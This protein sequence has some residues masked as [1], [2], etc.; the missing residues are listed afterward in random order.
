ML[1]LNAAIAQCPR[2]LFGDKEKKE[3]PK[4]RKIF[5]LVAKTLLK[6]AGEK[7][8]E[9][10]VD[11]VAQYVNPSS[12]Q[13]SVADHRATIT[14]KIDT[15][16][17]KYLP[18]EEKAPKKERGKPRAKKDEDELGLGKP[19]KPEKSKKVEAAKKAKNAVKKAP[20]KAEKKAAPGPKDTGASPKL[21]ALAKARAA[22]AAAKAKKEADAKKSKAPAKKPA[23][24]TVEI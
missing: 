5:A 3:P 17:G 4:F 6:E 19:K 14:G 16:T 15:K 18:V 7:F 11:L 13:R 10:T 23:E 20:A 9:K 24:E 22:L 12:M 2:S 8:D 1:S 21:T